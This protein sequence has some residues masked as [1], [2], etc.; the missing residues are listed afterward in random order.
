MNQRSTPIENINQCTHCKTPCHNCFANELI[1]FQEPIFDLWISKFFNCLIIINAKV[2]HLSPHLC[3]VLLALIVTGVSGNLRWCYVF[4][5]CFFLV[6]T[7]NLFMRTCSPQ[8]RQQPC[9]A[10]PGTKRQYALDT[11]TSRLFPKCK[12][13]HPASQKPKRSKSR[14]LSHHYLWMTFM[15]IKRRRTTTRRTRTN[16]LTNNHYDEIV[17]TVRT[18]AASQ[19][20]WQETQPKNSEAD[21]LTIDDNCKQ[22]VSGVP[23]VI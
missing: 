5:R 15:M 10:F 21:T 17:L 2:H 20:S 3:K 7:S 19:F 11:Q 22:Y 4:L 13:K 16:F 23:T 9:E 1:A 8:W 14:I 6:S 18:A 12:K